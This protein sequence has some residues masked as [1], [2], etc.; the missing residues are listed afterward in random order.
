MIKTP[1]KNGQLKA[2]TN[3]LIK[4][5]LRKLSNEEAFKNGTNIRTALRLNGVAVRLFL[6]AELELTL[7]LVDAATTMQTNEEKLLALDV[8]LE[9]FPAFTVEEFYLMFR[10]IAYGKHKLYN[11]LKLAEFLEVGRKFEGTRAIQILEVQHRPGYDPH[12]RHSEAQPLRKFL[13]L[14]AGDLN[15]IEKAQTKKKNANQSVG[16]SNVTAG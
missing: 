14:T 13:A 10:E 6:L 16:S 8:M 12:R 11:R 9:H 4:K 2:Q 15:E 7:Q 1:S 3:S 5:D